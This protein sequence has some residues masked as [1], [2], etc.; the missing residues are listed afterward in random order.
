MTRGPGHRSLIRAEVRRLLARAPAFQALPEVER[1]QLERGLV[2]VTEQ[3]LRARDPAAASRE[4][5]ESLRRAAHGQ[6]ADLDRLRTTLAPG[7]ARPARQLAGVDVPSFVAALIQ[8][9]FQATV[10]S[11]IQ[12]M[13]AYAKLLADVAV[14]SSSDDDDD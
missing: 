8:G 10:D 5:T 1:A 12:Q 9:T 3:V 7:T 11:S 13:D 2:Q 6:A 4:V 14:S